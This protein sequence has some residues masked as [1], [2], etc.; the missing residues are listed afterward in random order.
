MFLRIPAFEEVTN[1]DGTKSLQKI[2]YNLDNLIQGEEWRATSQG[3]M[4]KKQR[5]NM[6]IDIE[7]AILTS[8]EGSEQVYKPGNFDTVK[9]WGKVSRIIDN[10][11]LRRQFI[12]QYGHLIG[13]N[14]E[15]VEEVERNDNA[16]TILKI[17]HH[18]T[19]ENDSERDTITLEDLQDFLDNGQQMN[20]LL[21]QTYNYM[22]TQNMVGASLVGV[23]ANGASMHTKM[24]E[25]YLSI[26]DKHVFD[27]AGYDGTF[28]RI[29]S[30][31]EQTTEINGRILYIQESIAQLQAA[32]VDNAKDPTLAD[33]YQSMFTAGTAL[34][35]ARAGLD[36]EELSYFFGVEKSTNKAGLDVRPKNVNNLLSH[37]IRRFGKVDDAKHV[38]VEEII[39]TNL[40][41][42]KYPELIK[43]YL[44]TKTSEKGDGTNLDSEL[45]E[46]LETYGEE[47]N[48]TRE[49]M[50]EILQTIY[51]T[52]SVLN[53][54][55]TLKDKLKPVNDIMQ[56][57]STN[58][59]LAVSIPE[60]V[61]QKFEVIRVTALVNDE[62]FP[63]KGNEDLK[64]SDEFIMDNVITSI[65]S[66]T[67]MEAT[68]MSRRLPH[69]Q[70]FYS[71][72]IELPLGMMKDFLIQGNSE[73]Q[74]GLINLL[75]DAPDSVF[76]RT[77]DGGF[78]GTRIVNSYFREYMQYLLST[79][80]EFG[81]SDN[82]SYDVKRM[83]YLEK[84]A[85]DFMKLKKKALNTSSDKLT[86]L[87]KMLIYNS[88]LSRITIT[89][90]SGENANQV[91][92]LIL[93]KSG[94]LTPLMKASIRRDL[95]MLLYSKDPEIVKLGINLFK[96]SFY[97]N[98]FNYGPNAFGS[99]FDSVYWN[100]MPRVISLLRTF[101]HNNTTVAKSLNNFIPMFIANHSD[102]VNDTILFTYNNGASW[103]GK[104]AIGEIEYNEDGTI[105]VDRGKK[106]YGTRSLISS[107][108]RRYIRVPSMDITGHYIPYELVRTDWENGKAIYKPIPVFDEP[109]SVY[110]ANSTAKKMM[111]MYFNDRK[112]KIQARLDAI[113]AEEAKNGGSNLSTTDTGNT[114]GIDEANSQVDAAERQSASAVE[115]VVK[116]SAAEAQAQ[117]R[118][119]SSVEAVMLKTNNEELPLIDPKTIE[120]AVNAEA[121][122]MK[123]ATKN[124]PK[125]ENMIDA[126]ISNVSEEQA[127][128]LK[129]IIREAKA[130][131][132]K[133]DKCNIK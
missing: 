119:G 11:N 72:G 79:T 60:A 103:T 83:Y 30:L 68:L 91:P 117:D 3:S 23:Y 35:M 121:Q 59:A 129:A 66:R 89:R 62:Y 4:T 24:Q 47:H 100:A 102:D 93:P 21:P 48:L 106:G 133:I 114:Q 37:V 99:Y 44:N 97:N 39:N 81:D 5:D 36:L 10:A 127:K 41:V 131:Y 52:Y 45:E 98:G 6:M 84:F 46:F 31:H 63:F 7:Y 51:N 94:K 27:I 110:N 116:M 8:V 73:L 2:E 112:A 57:D 86:P 13:L 53:N 71:L 104:P 128:K 28:R 29:Q 118:M 40:Y 12:T 67:E 34:M 65:Q 76:N 18:K 58:H 74:E 49:E 120:D 26:D 95:D 75:R 70:A 132:D 105:I 96:Y 64:M 69:I 20:A 108:D 33:L 61:L 85:K 111:K 130:A 42:Q 80:E 124:S 82:E 109:H 55:K 14:T 16:A 122:F 87:Q 54:I 123:T 125:L 25:T 126:S 77:S 88:T 101:R 17:L 1:E 15:D 43:K 78:G 107:G 113:E 90:P 92:Q 38:T 9:K 50:D 19:N 115:T 32:S 22:H 56:C